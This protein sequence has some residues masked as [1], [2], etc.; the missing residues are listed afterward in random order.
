MKQTVNGDL[1]VAYPP[2]GR[3][4]KECYDDNE[5][6]SP[7]AG[8]R[9]QCCCGCVAPR[10]EVKGVSSKKPAIQYRASD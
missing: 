9:R 7:T 5:A 4:K 10:V 3:R 1:I 2:L 8:A 6:A